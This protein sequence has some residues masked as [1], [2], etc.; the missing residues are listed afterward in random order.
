MR[1][2]IL[3]AL[4]LGLSA[5]AETPIR[6]TNC[7]ATVNSFAGGGTTNCEFKDVSAL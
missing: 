3:I 5:C 6:K 1:N 4:A 7:W 2:L